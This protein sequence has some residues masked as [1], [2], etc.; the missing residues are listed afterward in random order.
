MSF[1]SFIK[2]S[3]TSGVQ[4][5]R[6]TAAQ[7]K[8]L[9]KSSFANKSKAGSAKGKAKPGSYPIPD[10]KHA[11]QALRMV[12]AHGDSATKARVRA[13][14]YKKFPELKKKKKKK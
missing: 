4:E 8:K 14:V 1:I 2:D 9:P 10:K 6:L 7:R 3:S 13:A 12:A 5:K 11:I